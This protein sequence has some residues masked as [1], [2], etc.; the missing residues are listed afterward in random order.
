MKK[1]QDNS[2]F[3][4]YG[5]TKKDVKKYPVISRILKQLTPERMKKE[6]EAIQKIELSPKVDR[7]MLFAILKIA[8]REGS[9]VLKNE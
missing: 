6:V 8:H 9:S 4:Y 1:I 2:L 7:G 3:N 5:F